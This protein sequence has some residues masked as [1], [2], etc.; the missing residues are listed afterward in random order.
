[1]STL[2]LV[3]AVDGLNSM[4]EKGKNAGLLAGLPGSSYSNFCNLQYADD[5]LLFGQNNIRE[6]I[7][8]K[9]VAFF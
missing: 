1:M 3:L 5:T 4:I 6:A 8:I 2:L 9:C 7:I